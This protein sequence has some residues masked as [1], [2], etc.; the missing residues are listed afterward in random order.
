[1]SGWRMGRTRG[2]QK[3]EEEEEEEAWV[4]IPSKWL[5]RRDSSACRWD[6]RGDE[7]KQRGKATWP[8]EGE[9]R[10]RGS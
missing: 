8:Q 3:E 2:D 1:M 4:C 6:E 7:G 10:G 5:A 9:E